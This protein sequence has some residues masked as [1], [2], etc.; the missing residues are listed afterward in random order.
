MPEV[1]GQKNL[2]NPDPPH[3][4]DI[5]LDLK[6]FEAFQAIPNFGSHFY[7]EFSFEQLPKCQNFSKFKVSMENVRSLYKENF[8]VIDEDED[9][10]VIAIE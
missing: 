8:Q 6:E 1:N 2:D 10:E 4:V 3:K 5:S 9:E 7:Y